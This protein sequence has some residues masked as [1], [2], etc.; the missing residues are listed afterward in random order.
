M[1]STRATLT[2]IENGVFRDWREEEMD[3]CCPTGTVSVDKLCDK[4]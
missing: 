3:R 1:A 2:E 4:F